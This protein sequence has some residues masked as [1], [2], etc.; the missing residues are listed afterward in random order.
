MDTPGT[1]AISLF[2]GGAGLDLGVR[3]VRPDV[4]VVCYVE[5]EAYACEVLA[6]R[7]EEEALAPAPI[8]SDVST[9]DGRPW[10][11][12]VD[13]IFGG[14]PCQDISN[15]GKRAGIT[16]ARSGLW[17]EFARIIAEVQPRLVF[18]ENVAA[19]VARGLET[20]LA[21][22]AALG[23]DAEWG[24]LRA[25]DVGAPHGRNRV[26]IL[27]NAPRDGWVE[28][29]PESDG[30]GFGSSRVALANSGGARLEGCELPSGARSPFSRASDSG[31]ELANADPGRWQRQRRGRLFDEL[32]EALRHDADRR[33]GE[34]IWP[35][36]RDA[37][38]SAFRAD[39][40]P[41]VCRASNGLAN[42]VE[43][44]RLCGNG[45]APAQAAFAW[46]QLESRWRH[47]K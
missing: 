1:N 29:W 27:A 43:Q 8:W 5:R 44:L 21:D 36:G 38:P 16:G 41:S 40:E 14:F 22:L 34:S 45:V 33:G 4:R 17:R 24:C 11:G 31:A 28:R 7:M 19:L 30:R 15:A 2:S 37:P 39:L 46:W 23:F 47:R 26:F 13:C 18:I 25:S 35:P 6:T 3:L 32:R 10:C 9:F 12:V 42:R 20:V